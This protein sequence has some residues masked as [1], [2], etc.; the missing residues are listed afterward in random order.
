MTNIDKSNQR[1]L[2]LLGS[3]IREIR[4][5]RGL[6]LRQIAAHLEVDTALMS[7]IERGERK[8]SKEMIYKLSHYLDTDPATLLKL[9]VADRIYYAIDEEVSMAEEAMELV[10]KTLKDEAGSQAD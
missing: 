10:K 4:E 8:P 7:R 9:W 6:L 1:T 3:K 5:Q 2:G